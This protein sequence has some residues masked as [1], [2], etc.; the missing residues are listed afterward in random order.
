MDKSTDLTHAVTAT[1]VTI[2]GVATGLSY[3]ILLAGFAGGLVSLSFIEPQ[4]I[5]RR[6]WTLSS[7]TLLAGYTAPVALA[8]IYTVSP[9]GADIPP[10]FAGFCMGLFGQALIPQILQRARKALNAP[11]NP[12]QGK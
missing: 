9:E 4:G 7:A 11:I 8:W 1:G 5:W 6:I 2:M 10:V 12:S 3:D